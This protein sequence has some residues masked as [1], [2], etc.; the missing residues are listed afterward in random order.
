MFDLAKRQTGRPSR[1]RLWLIIIIALL[2]PLTAQAQESTPAPTPSER[3]VL[4]TNQARSQRGLPPFL[5]NPLLSQVAQAHVADITA[6]GHLGHVG[7]DGSRADERVRRAGYQAAAVGE[8]WVFS[9]TLEKGFAWWMA[10]PP[11]FD[12]LMHRRY[13]EIGVGM[14]P[15]GDGWGEVW[16]MVFAVSLDGST[17]PDA[18]LVTGPAPATAVATGVELTPAPRANYIVQSGD[19]LEAIGRRFGVP[20]VRIAQ[21]NGISDPTRLQV[22]QAL[23]IPTATVEPAPGASPE[24]TSAAPPP[25]E[26]P[27]QA[28]APEAQATPAAAP[29]PAA[30]SVRPLTY[31]VQSG[32]TLW[33]IADRFGLTWQTLAG[34]NGLTGQSVLRPGQALRLTAAARLSDTPAAAPAIYR[35]RRGD[36][37]ASI[38]ARFGINW[39]R[40]AQINGLQRTSILRVGQTLRLR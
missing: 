36:S 16:V 30:P 1:A 17:A 11:H 13:T 21:V 2:T 37:L 24:P 25:A 12:N 38:G 6:S 39:Q 33:K 8:N 4:L 23:E 15:Y 18:V 14:A 26:T 20:W 10:D 22:G 3:M 28:A 5:L 9:R 34:W 27:Q 40:L 35:V 7:S 31:I 29:T 19:T 32:D